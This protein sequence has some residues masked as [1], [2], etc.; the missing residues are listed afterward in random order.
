MPSEFV[1]FKDKLDEVHPR[2][3]SHRRT[4]K[5]ALTEHDRTALRLGYKTGKPFV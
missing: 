5:L 4:Q 3:F 1:K 2:K